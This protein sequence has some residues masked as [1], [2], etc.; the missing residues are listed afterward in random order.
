[1]EKGRGQFLAQGSE[2]HAPAVIQKGSLNSSLIFKLTNCSE[3]PPLHAFLSKRQVGAAMSL[4][5]MGLCNSGSDPFPC[6]SSGSLQQV[7]STS[8]LG[9]KPQT[10][11]E[12]LHDC[13]LLAPQGWELEGCSMT[14]LR[15]RRMAEATGVCLTPG[16]VSDIARGGGRVLCFAAFAAW[17]RQAQVSRG[18]QDPCR[19]KGSSSAWRNSCLRS[20]QQRTRGFPSTSRLRNGAVRLSSLVCA[21]LLKSLNLHL[22]KTDPYDFCTVIQLEL[23]ALLWKPPT[24]MENPGLQTLLDR[25]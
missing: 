19:T 6:T 21:N 24:S 2:Q 4:P 8:Q 22:G 25:G 10:S 7:S 18:T 20:P 16:G 14:T 5:V 1:M 17:R 23:E 3:K 15:L 13:R 12:P 9:A 11:K